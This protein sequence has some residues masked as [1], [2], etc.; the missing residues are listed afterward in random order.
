MSYGEH[1]EVLSPPSLRNKI[2]E[3]IIQSLKK[4]DE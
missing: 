1:I 2:K 3:R 4:Y